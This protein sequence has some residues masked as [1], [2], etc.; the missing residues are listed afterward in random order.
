MAKPVLDEGLW[1]L[2]EPIL[3]KRKRRRRRYSGRKPLG[4][5]QR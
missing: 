5:V 2:I 4:A 3:P 1:R